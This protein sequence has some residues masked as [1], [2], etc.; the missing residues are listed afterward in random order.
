MRLINPA[1]LLDHVG[2]HGRLYMSLGALLGLLAPPLASLAA[3]VLLPALLVTTI[4]A[5]VR[6]DWRLLRDYAA[7][8]L[9]LLPML[10]GSLLFSPL[11]VAA[12]LAGLEL[13]DSLR[14]AM[15]LVAASAPIFANAAFALILGLDAALATVICVAATAL[16]PFTMPPFALGLLGMSLNIDALA[17]GLRLGAVVG[18][19]FLVAWGIRRWAAP[20]A[21]Q[22]HAHALDGAAVLAAL[23]FVLA[24]M[25]GMTALAIERPA[26][27]LSV[28]VAAL[29]FNLSLQALGLLLAWPFGA[30]IAVTTAMT[31]GNCNMGLVMVALGP[32]ADAQ[33]QAFF[34][35][36]QLPMY[37]LPAVMLPLY[38]WIVAT[39]DNRNSARDRT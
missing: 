8:P 34:A 28:T 29:L 35:F 20:G 15:V 3:P 32:Q 30:S 10:L 31:F 36:G 24:I 38:R 33:M 23:L 5:L 9:L 1:H 25:D 22:R 26:F 19:A 21:L 39:A 14:A 18:A 17:L 12:L 6:V 27:V 13:P 16:V 4:V 37:I 2:R 7:R 11:L